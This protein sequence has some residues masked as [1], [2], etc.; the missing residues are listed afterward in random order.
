M[1]ILEMLFSLFLMQIVETIIQSENKYF[2][3]Y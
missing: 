1:H 3:N 2:C